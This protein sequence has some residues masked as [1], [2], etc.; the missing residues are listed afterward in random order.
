MFIAE[1]RFCYCFCFNQTSIHFITNEFFLNLKLL[2]FCFALS[3]VFVSISQHYINSIHIHVPYNMHFEKSTYGERACNEKCN[4]YSN[5]LFVLDC[6]VC[7][8]RKYLWIDGIH[9][10]LFK[11]KQF[12]FEENKFFYFF[13]V[14]VAF[15]KEMKNKKIPNTCWSN[16]GEEKTHL[17]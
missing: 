8:N 2:S 5:T 13:Y 12:Y 16:V 7:K 4:Y 1:Q 6:F 9:V 15:L 3:H 11:F 10:F 14:K 17:N